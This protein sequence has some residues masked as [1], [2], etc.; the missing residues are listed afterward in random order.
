MAKTEKV[1][2][3]EE[4]RS[5]IYALI[6]IKH[7]NPDIGEMTFK[8]KRGLPTGLIMQGKAPIINP[9]MTALDEKKDHEEPVLAEG[10]AFIKNICRAALIEP[11]FDSIEDLIG[12]DVFIMGSIVKEAT[13]LRLFGDAMSADTFRALVEGTGAA[14][15]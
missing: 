11:T 2:T 7:A 14:A 13:G 5:K 15:K 9:F 3:A 10:M 4:L 1:T 8:I 12:D 6:T